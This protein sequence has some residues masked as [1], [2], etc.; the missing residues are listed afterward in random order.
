MHTYNQCQHVVV[1]ILILSF[2]MDLINTDLAICKL[3]CI[4]IG[5]TLNLPIVCCIAS[6]DHCIFYGVV[7]NPFVWYAM[8]TVQYST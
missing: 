5:I 3:L 8:D 6:V 1:K 4:L 2:F 7:S